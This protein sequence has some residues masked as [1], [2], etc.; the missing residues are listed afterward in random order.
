MPVWA[1]ANGSASLWD[2]VYM[3]SHAK[4]FAVAVAGIAFGG[5]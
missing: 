5:S 3:L 2:S 1:F 4:A